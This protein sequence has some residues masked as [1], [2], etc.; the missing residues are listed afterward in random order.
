[1][2]IGGSSIAIVENFSAPN[3]NSIG[4]VQIKRLPPGAALGAHDMERWSSNRSGGRSGAYTTKAE[5][6]VLNNWTKKKQ[7][8]E[9]SIF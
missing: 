1:M 8:A 6:E 7:V 3:I 9:P 5:R 2:S 4:G